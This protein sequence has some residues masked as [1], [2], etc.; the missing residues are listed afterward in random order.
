M[1]YSKTVEPNFRILFSVYFHPRGRLLL[2]WINFNPSID[3]YSNAQ[4]K[5]GIKLLIQSQTSTLQ[6]MKFGNESINSSHTL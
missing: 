1:N 6:L 4:V 2:T 5:Y 3:N